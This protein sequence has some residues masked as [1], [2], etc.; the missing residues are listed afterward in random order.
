MNRLK[1]SRY[2]DL[3]NSYK[4][5]IIFCLFIIQ[6]LG[7]TIAVIS[8]KSL[9]PTNLY[10][11]YGFILVSLLANLFIPKITKGDKIFLLLVNL[12]YTIGLIM[13]IRL[14][15]SVVK[16]H[17][18]WYMLG[19]L[20][21]LFIYLFFK[22]FDNI[23][24]NKFLVFFVLIIL[25]FVATFVLGHISGGAKNWIRIGS[26]FTIQLS[27][28]AKIPF[29]LLIGSYYGAK[30]KFS[31]KKYGKYILIVCTYIFS[32]LFFYQG[33]LGTAIIFVALVLASIFIFEERYLFILL[34]IVLALIAIYAASLV[35][36]HIKVRFNIWLDP[37]SD[38]RNKGYQIIQGLFS[39]ANGGFFGTGIGL[40]SPNS[41]PVVETDFIL[42]AIIEEM[43][44]LMA[45]VIIL[46]Y[47]I[48]FYK[49]IKVSL[50]FKSEY[51]SSISMSIGFLYSLQAL[52]MF[53]GILKLI[54]LTGITTPFLS[55]GGSSTISNFMLLGI[56]QYITSKLG[57]NYEKY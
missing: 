53:G 57:E 42:S 7:I 55:Y 1:E 29:I 37:W 45:V 16:N 34:N 23:L 47:I 52:I 8:N 33:E 26:S 18:I 38:F 51:Y 54:P 31:D 56:L 36:S 43:G 6:I 28:F 32:L 2:N 24:K 49:S 30:N 14:N 12:L 50:Q 13:M 25:T 40:G 3:R 10:Y 5:T 48:I 21:Y 15:N 4:Y 19:L 44:I 41:V 17:V 22:Y 35:L 20:V 39:I 46:L 27:E 9:N 11:I